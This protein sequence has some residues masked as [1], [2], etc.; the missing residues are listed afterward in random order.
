MIIF[1][2]VG[3]SCEGVHPNANFSININDVHCG[4]SERIFYVC[5]KR[6]LC[7][8]QSLNSTFEC[9]LIFRECYAC[10]WLKIWD[11]LH[12]LDARW[13]SLLWF[14]HFTMRICGG[15]QLPS[16]SY[17]VDHISIPLIFQMNLIGN[18]PFWEDETWFFTILFFCIPS[19]KKSK[20]LFMWSPPLNIAHFLCFKMI[21]KRNPILTSKL[22]YE[23][24]TTRLSEMHS[25]Q[26]FHQ[27][28][29]WRINEFPKTQQNPSQRHTRATTSC[30]R[31]RHHIIFG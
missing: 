26:P 20:G 12:T 14:A 10:M 9:F 17:L 28:G 25:K 8:H 16:C 7:S 15:M 24:S 18:D 19:L 3:C 13:A 21:L 31:R 5:G 6:P 27:L 22:T 4:K 30:I 23:N 29:K 2:C 11:N 1:W